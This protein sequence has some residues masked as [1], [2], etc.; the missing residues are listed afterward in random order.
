[1]ESDH[2]GTLEPVPAHPAG[3]EPVAPRR[4]G[5]GCLMSAGATVSAALFT[6]EPGVN[7]PGAPPPGD[8]FPAAGGTAAT[9]RRVQVSGGN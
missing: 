9:E 8:R 5:S 1:M 6:T 7:G 2:T 3:I 4:K